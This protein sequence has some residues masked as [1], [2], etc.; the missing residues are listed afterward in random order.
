MSEYENHA[1]GALVEEQTLILEVKNICRPIEMDWLKVKKHPEAAN[2]V[3]DYVRQ[4]SKANRQTVENAV[5]MT[6]YSYRR[7]EVIDF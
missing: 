6:T 7:N 5:L 2:G 3:A 1:N 4:W